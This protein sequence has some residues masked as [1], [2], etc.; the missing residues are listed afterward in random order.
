MEELFKLILTYL[1]GFGT[2]AVAL[3]SDAVRRWIYDRFDD[4][5]R[6]REERRKIS[7]EIIEICVE[8]EHRRFDYFPNEL[9]LNLLAKL[10]TLEDEKLGKQVKD[11]FDK[12]LFYARNNR[13]LFRE[14]YDREGKNLWAITKK[15]LK[16]SCEAITKRLHRWK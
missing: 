11:F 3:M 15:D 16:E 12:W 1:A 14:Q 2:L 10:L 8:A 13:P 6:K 9:R 5:K 4:G 7:R